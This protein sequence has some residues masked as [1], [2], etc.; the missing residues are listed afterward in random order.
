MYLV[1]QETGSLIPTLV[2]VRI[3]KRNLKV[4]KQ[5]PVV[6]GR[7]LRDAEDR[8]SHSLKSTHVYTRTADYSSVISLS[9]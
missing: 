4:Q 3:N 7:D 1:A 2:A 8:G 6:T 9:N 5:L